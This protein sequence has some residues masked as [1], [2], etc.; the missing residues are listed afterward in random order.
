MSS[1]AGGDWS[2]SRPNDGQQSPTAVLALIRNLNHG[3]HARART[4]W[5]FTCEQPVTDND[6]SLCVD[7]D[8]VN[9]VEKERADIERELSKQTDHGRRIAF[10]NGSEFFGRAALLPEP[11]RW[12]VL[13]S[14]CDPNPDRNYHS[15]SLASVRTWPALAE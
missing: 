5:L 1:I 15:I 12:Q 11:A 14:D 6:G 8:E 9:D 10:E 13:H 3:I 4:S 7:L 2:R